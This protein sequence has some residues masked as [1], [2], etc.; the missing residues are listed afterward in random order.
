MPDAADNKGFA[1]KAATALLGAS[2]SPIVESAMLGAGGALLGRALSG[3]AMNVFGG[4]DVD[5]AY[6]RRLQRAMTIIG[7]LTGAANPIVRSADF[8]SVPSFFSS[9]SHK[10]SSFDMTPFLGTIDIGSAT[11]AIHRDSF[12][13]PYEKQTAIEVIDRAPQVVNGKTSQYN[14]FKSAAKAGVSFVPAYAFGML[15]GKALGMPSDTVSQLSKMGALAY[16]VRASG[17]LDQL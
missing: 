4:P 13:N 6:R 11:S 17:L 5:L 12:L 3:A 10:A 16:A 15:A 1:A 2:R 9:I 8:S 14:L 7:A